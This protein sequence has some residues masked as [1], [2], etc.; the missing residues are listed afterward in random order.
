MR[1]G[2][3]YGVCSPVILEVLKM[4]LQIAEWFELEIHFAWLYVRAG[5]RDFYLGSL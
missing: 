1:G 3:V 5:R 2:G 4:K